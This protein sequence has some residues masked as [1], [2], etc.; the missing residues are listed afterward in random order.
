MSNFLTM[1]DKYNAG[2]KYY[3]V[4]PVD[5]AINEDGRYVEGTFVGYGISNKATGVIEHTNICLPAALYQATHFDDM[6]ASL[7]DV[8][9]KLSIVSEPVPGDDVLPN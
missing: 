4:L 6:L 3:E 1:L 9:P 5:R 8:N 7:L 2:L